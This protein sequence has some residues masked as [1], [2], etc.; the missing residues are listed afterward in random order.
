[1]ACDIAIFESNIQASSKMNGTGQDETEKDITGIVF[2][3]GMNIA[4]KTGV[5][6]VVIS[7]ASLL[8]SA[9]RSYPD[10]GLGCRAHVLRSLGVFCYP[11]PRFKHAHFPSETSL[12][13]GF[14]PLV[15]YWST[16]HWDHAARYNWEPSLTRS[17]RTMSESWSIIC[18]V[19]GC[20]NGA[21]GLKGEPPGQCTTQKDA[22][23]YVRLSWELKCI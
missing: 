22:Y 18:Q 15:R 12:M 13:I 21:E 7:V 17:L 9:E 20:W 16:L 14:Q 6:E 19:Q 3:A 23:P 4:V 1:M 2:S 11:R 10:L 8:L 5:K